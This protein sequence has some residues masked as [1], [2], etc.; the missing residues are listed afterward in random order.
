MNTSKKFFFLTGVFLLLSFFGHAQSQSQTVMIRAFEFADQTAGSK[1]RMHVHDPFGQ[2]QTV[3]LSLPLSRNLDDLGQHARIIS[4][5]YVHQPNGEV[6]RIYGILDETTG[7]GNARTF[8]ELEA[9]WPISYYARL[10]GI[11][12]SIKSESS[13]ID[14][15]GKHT[16]F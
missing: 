13:V 2:V 1:P 3:A 6:Q 7:V 5:G 9:D 11:D 16:G 15:P 14:K 12:V 8:T 10:F 4:F